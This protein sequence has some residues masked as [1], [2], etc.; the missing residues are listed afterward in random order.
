MTK[1]ELNEMTNEELLQE[2]RK[3]KNAKII[4]A[5]IIG[6]MIGVVFWSVIKNTWGLLTLIPLFI[7]YKIAGNSKKDN[8][9]EK[10]LKE[11]NLD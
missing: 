2:K 5:T 9:L 8:D 4:N 3:L 6:L 11:R 7:I 1:K 10:L